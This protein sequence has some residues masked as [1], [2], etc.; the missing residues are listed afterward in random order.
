MCVSRCLKEELAWA[1]GK[2]FQLNEVLRFAT[3]ETSLMI[4][5][6]Y[7]PSRKWDLAIELQPITK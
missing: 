2:W 4:S 5:N 6:Q 1:I 7:A 3:I